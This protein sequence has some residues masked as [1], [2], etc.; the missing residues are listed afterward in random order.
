MADLVTVRMKR[1]PFFIIGHMVN[2]LHE[3]DVF[4]NSGANALEADIQFSAN[5]TPTRVYHGVPCDCLRECTRYAAIPEYLDYLRGVTSKDGGK[6]N[7][8]ITFLYLDLKTSSIKSDGKYPAGRAISTYVIKHLWRKVSPSDA[9]NV[10]FYVE[11]LGDREILKGISDSINALPNATLWRD[12]VGFD[13][14]GMDSLAKVGR[15]FA[16]LKIY[17][18]RWV[19]SGNTNCLPYLSGKYDRLKD[20]VACR[21]GLKSGCDFIDKGYAWTLDYESSIARE[22]KLGL[23]GVITNYPRNA[24]A[25]LKRDDVARIARLAGPEDS[26]WTRVYTTR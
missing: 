8:K 13:F 23:D 16:D 15:A 22:I 2:S 20:I 18:H 4:V 1:R 17:N 7:G 6:F 3:V 25:A 21:D 10:L 24:I 14:G 12:R 11:G 5:G 19:G 9:L 26:A